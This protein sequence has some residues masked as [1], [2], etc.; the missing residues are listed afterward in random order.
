LTALTLA[1]VGFDWR[2]GIRG[3][4]ALTRLQQLLLR[5]LEDEHGDGAGEGVNWFSPLPQLRQLTALTVEWDTYNSPGPCAAD[6]AAVVAQLTGLRSLELCVQGL[7]A[8]GMACLLA[9]TNLTK[10]QCCYST[11]LR[12]PSHGGR[13]PCM[14]YSYNALH[15]GQGEVFQQ[16]ECNLTSTVSPGR[17]YDSL[18]LTC[19]PGAFYLLDFPM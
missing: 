8:V 11:V 6:A 3:I 4:S 19:L 14:A 2:A 13:V 17:T 9:L 7:T 12:R 15:G 16:G 5:N 18:S 1:N 10:L